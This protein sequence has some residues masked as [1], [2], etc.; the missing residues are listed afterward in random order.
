[1]D[2]L[3][4]DY[5]IGIRP[6]VARI[7]EVLHETVNGYTQ[8]FMIIDALDE[9]DQEHRCIL[10]KV[11]FRLQTMYPIHLL[12]TS[13]VDPKIVAL[14]T[15]ADVL[16]IR[17]DKEDMRAYLA[18][19]MSRAL[20]AIGDNAEL[21]EEISSSI[22]GA[23][24]GRFLLASLYLECLSRQTSTK[25]LRDTLARLVTGS[26]SDNYDAAYDSVVKG[27]EN[28]AP[29]QANLA[30][31]SLLYMALARRPLTGH[32]LQHAIAV[33][34]GVAEQTLSSVHF[35]RDVVVACQGLAV[36]TG[37]EQIESE[38]R[39]G[40]IGLRLVHRTA[41][42]SL[43]RTLTRWF[44]EGHNRFAKTCVTVL[45]LPAFE[46]GPC[47]TRQELEHRLRAFPFYRYAASNWGHHARSVTDGFQELESMA[48]M[49]LDL[50]E[51]QPKIESAS[52][53]LFLA[54][55]HIPREPDFKSFP[56]RMGAL[57]VAGYFGLTAMIRR[58]LS[59]GRSILAKDSYG[60]TALAWAAAEGHEEA[61]RLLLEGAKTAGISMDPNTRDR[62]GRTPISLASE[63]CNTA[64]V[65]LLLHHGANPDL[66]DFG[67]EAPL[68]YVARGGHTAI[69]E[70]LIRHGV[71]VDT[72]GGPG[73]DFG[74]TPLSLAA[75]HGHAD[76]VRLLLT[77]EGLQPWASPGHW[78]PI[79]ET[80]LWLAAEHGHGDVVE[81]LLGH[82]GISQDQFIDS[83][84]GTPLHVAAE[85]GHLDVVQ[86]LLK[87][88]FDVN[89]QTRFGETPLL[90]A[91]RMGHD[92][93]VAILLSQA[94]VMIDLVGTDVPSPI[95]EAVNR[96]QTGALRLLLAHKANAQVRDERGRTPLALSAF[97]GFEQG[98]ELLL[99]TD[100]V[101]P[102]EKDNE[103]L[104][105]LFLAVLHTHEPESD[106]GRRIVRCLL[107]SGR[108][109][110]NIHDAEG[111]TPVMHA[112]ENGCRSLCRMLLEC[113]QL[114][115]HAKDQD[116][117]TPLLWAVKNNDQ[118]T[119][120]LLL[121]RGSSP[122]VSDTRGE[123]A[124]SHVAW[125][126][127]S[128]M[129]EMLLG[130]PGVDPDHRNNYGQ[131]PLSLAASCA[132]AK[133]VEL[134]LATGRVDV[135]SR[136]SSGETPL[137][138]VSA[139]DYSPEEKSTVVKL[140]LATSDIEP[141]CKDQGGR[142]PLCLAAGSRH[143][144]IAAML[145]ATGRVDV[146][147]QDKE[148]WAPLHHAAHYDC[149]PMVERLLAERNV[150]PNCRDARGRTPLSLAAEAGRIKAVESFL[151]HS[152]VMRDA[153]NNVGRTPLSLAVGRAPWSEFR[154]E[155]DGVEREWVAQQLLLADGVDP[156]AEDET[157]WTP[158]WWAVE[159][160][161]GTMV[162]KLLEHG[163]GRIDL[164]HV[165]KKGR[166]PLEL[167]LEAGSEVI[168]GLLLAAG[169]R[170][171]AGSTKETNHD[172][173]LLLP[174][175]DSTDIPPDEEDYNSSSHSILNRAV[176]SRWHT[177]LGIKLS[178]QGEEDCQGVDNE[179][180]LCAQ[181]DA[182]DIDRLFSRCP[183]GIS[184]GI[185]VS[186]VGNMDKRSRSCPMCRLMAAVKPVLDNDLD[187]AGCELRAFSSN[188]KWLGIDQQT[189]LSPN[190]VDTVFLGV[191]PPGKRQATTPRPSG[192]ISRVGSNDEYRENALTVN[193]L[194][195][196]AID[197]CKIRN[198]IDCCEVYHGRPCN[199]PTSRKI[200]HL[201]LIDCKSPELAIVA[202]SETV[203][204][205]A[206]SYVWGGAQGWT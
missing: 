137:H 111:V 54:Q 188:R 205:V 68:L 168:K 101:D 20:F 129:A 179:E 8:V 65:E 78:Q 98:V 105:P 189:D 194:R 195:T 72:R 112:L 151:S 51:S 116:G 43:Q 73:D 108:V 109:D 135:N 150:E 60:R 130:Q 18:G 11:I 104:T 117:L 196:D 175:T 6:S 27:I 33:D 16:K 50:P 159:S 102:D 114:D 19:R 34:A 71:D 186:K 52:Q 61:V 204:F 119:V 5:M 81:M 198:W 165:D 202:P 164:D 41:Y 77:D 70:L 25:A 187:A 62:W 123:T 161:N 140:L 146:N 86:L 197:Y 35:V 106:G 200:P 28:Q 88:G 44:P 100:G 142:T 157:G 131:T 21:E 64:V 29:C 127:E 46:A 163:A 82:E 42:N 3:R 171:S 147:S 154:P 38:Q 136:D 91:V 83:S 94:G 2:R 24:D 10:L 48:I 125:F 37:S 23:A 180:E 162:D 99:A 75:K 103:G 176:C 80:P 124:L 93:V 56:R 178:V 173:E 53:V 9:C 57:H 7:A 169:A 90:G 182:L 118:D 95:L 122:N 32:E 22:V 84:K 172:R 148:G 139:R 45:S 97:H 74:C 14:F 144:G 166:T 1:M 96:R 181:C 201:R 36:I 141:D 192:F 134:L 63:R 193:R 191:V 17:A 59:K 185:L 31:K 107:D 66:K 15:K 167:A 115:V 76:I 143:V 55:Q 153:R 67:K 184:K 47:P 12:A 206:L 85:N 40:T 30:K 170:L 152:G 13:D 87:R 158:L 138:R 49:G 174:G 156:D 58:L 149:G 155:E 113:E 183:M 190:W 133:V 177:V 145:L 110:V 92:S 126:G 79:S 26:H 203:P 120:A 4:D 128:S 39:D 89:A 121:A 199:T 160:R 132:N 69:T